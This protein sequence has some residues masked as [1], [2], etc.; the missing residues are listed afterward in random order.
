M[1]RRPPGPEGYYD[2]YGL[3]FGRNRFPAAQVVGHHGVWGRIRVLVSRAR[4]IITGI[5]NTGKVD[6]QPLL[7]EV[8]RA[9]TD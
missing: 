2:D 7:S 4:R 8:V 1:T 6:R 3:G 9:L 5:V